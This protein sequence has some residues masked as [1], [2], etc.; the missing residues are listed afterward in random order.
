[1]TAV[2]PGARAAD[3][4]APPLVC[5][6][7]VTVTYD[8]PLTY[9]PKPTT[10]SGREDFVCAGGGV[11]GGFA[12][13]TYQTTAGCTSLRLFTVSTTTY[14]W[15]TGQTSQ[16]TYTIT[17]IER[18]LN[19]TVLVTEQGTVTSGL[20][21]GRTAIYQMVL[22]QLDLLACLGAGVGHLSGTEVLTFL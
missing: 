19:G 3:D 14:H 7:T 22:P 18:L 17:A 12:A 15:D 5:Q 11:T 4:P 10:V 6:G 21:A 2:G 13:D 20:H 8:P 16:A 1:M 9:V